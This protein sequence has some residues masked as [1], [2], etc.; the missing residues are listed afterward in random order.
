MPLF[1]F[2]SGFLLSEHKL[3][4]RT[5]P[6]LRRLT[7]DLG[8]PYAI[9]FVLSYLYWLVT[10]DIGT[11]SGKFAATPWYD[12]FYGFVSG[13]GDALYVNPPLWFLPCL[14]VTALLYY[15][16][17]KRVSARQALLICVAVG[18]AVTVLGSHPVVR[19]PLGFD[20]AWAAL[21]FYAAG[22]CL[23]AEGGLSRLAAVSRRWW[24]VPL[25]L[26]WVGLVYL[27]GASDMNIMYFGNLPALYLPTAMLG[28]L[29]CMQLCATLPA[30]RL[31][32]WLAANTLVIFAS[33]ALAFNLFSGIGKNV[34][35]LPPA[36]VNTLPW[37]IA[38]TCLA[39]LL[40]VPGSMVLSKAFPAVF[41]S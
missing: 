16:L 35:H 7:H 1:F 33:H 3:G 39:I 6:Y 21:P 24:M 22:Q 4:E 18:V 9:F 38:T 14:I 20:N 34:L 11:K 29:L 13:R 40:C 26:L 31:Q 41:R 17:R 12:P 10:R 23:R 25:A 32:R 27:N 36:T 37:A 30:A 8:I 15:A 28:I 2:V 5:G 19:L